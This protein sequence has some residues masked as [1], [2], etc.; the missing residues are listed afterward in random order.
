MKLHKNEKEQLFRDRVQDVVGEDNPTWSTGWMWKIIHEASDCGRDL[1]ELTDELQG[2]ENDCK[3]A[4]EALILQ[5][6]YFT[7]TRSDEKFQYVAEQIVSVK[8]REV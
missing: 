2:I 3:R 6:N 8:R 5:Q 1:S 4:K 7:D